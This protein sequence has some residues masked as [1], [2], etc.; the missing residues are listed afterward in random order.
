MQSE[1]FVKACFTYYQS[2]FMKEIGI[3]IAL[4]L[5]LASCTYVGNN[6][7][8]QP[9]KQISF[10]LENKPHAYYVTQA[11]L[12]WK[13]I[14]KDP[15]AEEPWFNYYRACRN[16]QGTA[17]WR[18]DFIDESPYLRLGDSIVLLMEQHIP[19]T[20]TYNYVKGSTGAVDPSFGEY[21]EK[22][23][24]MNPDFPG[25][26]AA[27]VTYAIST[28]NPELRKEVNDKWKS[29]NTMHPG[30]LQYSQN[31]LSPLA[32]KA[33][34][35][36]QHDNDSYPAWMLQDSH[37]FRE[38]VQILNIDFLL[39][40]Q[41]QQKIFPMLGLPPYSLGE[42][43]VNDYR[44]NWKNVVQYILANYQGD[45]PLYLGLTVSPDWYEG[46]EDSLQL[47]GLT[48]RLH[49]GD[50]VQTDQ[51]LAICE[52][53]WKLETI[54]QEHEGYYG[55]AIVTELNINYLKALKVVFDHYLGGE[56][57]EK[58]ETVSQ[59]ARTIAARTGNDE[60]IKETERE[61]KNVQH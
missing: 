34:L 29:L 8:D 16:A 18:T 43:D 42:I 12:W 11:E 31:V 10:A 30:L 48:L 57:Y 5:V 49:T 44:K 46:F 37:G 3:V 2:P 22:A 24:A 53:L 56:E 23:Y 61:F 14:E 50:S 40:D 21:L 41:Y 6:D 13:E 59:T 36:T 47:H 35:L 25:I 45:R 4:L 28:H 26:Q 38:D 27:M 60:L 19:E 7:H 33:V 1:A 58:A 39:L 17:D 52:K 51:S 54:N 9:E 15:A 32:S 20:F 55:G